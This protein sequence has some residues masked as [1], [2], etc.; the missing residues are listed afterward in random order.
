MEEY[1][2]E[3]KQIIDYPRCRM[4]RQ[5][6][7]GLIEDTNIRVGGESGLYYY[8]V[9]SC[10]ANFRTSHHRIKGVTY[11]L[12]PGEWICKVEELMR[13]FRVR[14]KRQTISIMEKLQEKHLLKF[15]IVGQGD[16]IKYRLSG[17]A[18]YNRILEYNAP[19]QKDIGFFFMP[20]DFAA[21]LVGSG[22]N[23]EADALI[24]MW[25]NTVYNDPQVKGSETAPVVYMRNGTGSPLIGYSELA[26]RWGVSKATVGRYM[27]KLSELGYVNLM[28]YPGT[29]GSVI[30]LQGYMSTM[31]QV[32][33]VMVN[34][35]E[36]AMS[37]CIK[38]K[39]QEVIEE[40]EVDS[41]SKTANSVSKLDV[42]ILLT[43]TISFINAQ[44]FS[45]S[46]CGR[47]KYM[48]LELS[49]CKE[50][51]KS[52][53]KSIV[54]DKKYRLIVS[55]GEKKRFRYKIRLMPFEASSS[56]QT[57]YM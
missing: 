2:L 26:E 25:I 5:F 32:S 42:E 24:D 31:F 39:P 11:T 28:I 21:E 37:L 45:C 19:C 44:G 48:L 33:D 51:I 23:S 15:K 49:D 35:E 54:E 34:K 3:I 10:F 36:I 8:T 12:Y 41:V 17:W 40:I 43:K 29:H 50:D 22:K 14:N 30:S 52:K 4:H 53:I 7:R 38:L 47:M 18:K 16:V 6:V 1:K 20:V 13:W 55:C 56:A 27:K 46:N 57:L 9:L